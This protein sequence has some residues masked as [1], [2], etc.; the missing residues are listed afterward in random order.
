MTRSW[1]V[2]REFVLFAAYDMSLKI[3]CQVR[4]NL[5]QAK[6]LMDALIKVSLCI[7][8][9]CGSLENINSTSVSI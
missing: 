9:S 5:E 6:A 1:M 8:W 2:L 7:I 4:R 3:L